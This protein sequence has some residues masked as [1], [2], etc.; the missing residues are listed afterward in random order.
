MNGPKPV[1]TSA[2]KK[3]NQSSPRRLRLDGIDRASR[4][5]AALRSITCAPS[6]RADLVASDMRDRIGILAAAA[7]GRTAAWR[8]RK[9]QSCDADVV[10]LVI[11]IGLAGLYSGAARTWSALSS[12][13]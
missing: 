3:M 9:R 2:T 10:E 8:G 4:S 1:C 13:G 12:T 6:G 5:L 7:Q 11:I